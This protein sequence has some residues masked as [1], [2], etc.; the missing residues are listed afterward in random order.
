MEKNKTINKKKLFFY[1]VIVILILVAFIV[2]FFE[3]TKKSKEA[4]I[5]EFKPLW[6]MGAVALSFI[7]FIGSAITG[8]LISL[9]QK[10]TISKRTTLYINLTEGFFAGIT[11]FGSGAEPFQAY[12][13]MKNGA[14]GEKTTSNIIINFILYSSATS[15]VGGFLLLF[16]HDILAKA[17]KG[18]LLLPI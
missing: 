15:V 1:S 11:P 3:I 4:S 7:F 13:Y 5:I 6:F 18:G 16:Y 12:Y 17:L 8:F 10:F 9:V 2:A 14:K